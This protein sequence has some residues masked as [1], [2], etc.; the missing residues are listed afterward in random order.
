MRFQQW[1]KKN[2]WSADWMPP[3]HAWALL[4]FP[5]VE[6]IR[7]GRKPVLVLSAELHHWPDGT[8]PTLV[9]S[10]PASNLYRPVTVCRQQMTE[11]RSDGTVMQV[12]D[13]LPYVAQH[14]GKLTRIPLFPT[15]IYAFC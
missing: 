14:P 10:C 5:T 8:M 11:S 13:M 9:S 3:L 4:P 6:L 2:L 12:I 15:K 7:W 1:K